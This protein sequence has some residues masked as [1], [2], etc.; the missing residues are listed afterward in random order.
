M[1]PFVA[2]NTTAGTVSEVTR[3]CIITNTE[4]H[5]KMALSTG[6]LHPMSPSMTRF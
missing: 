6:G 2:I 3:F 5:V 1:A 4:T